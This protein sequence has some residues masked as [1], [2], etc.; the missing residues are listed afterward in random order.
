[1]TTGT[2]PGHLVLILPPWMIAQVLEDASAPV[3]AAIRAQLPPGP[4]PAPA[5]WPADELGRLIATVQGALASASPPTA[6]V[7]R[8]ILTGLV[9]GHMVASG[10]RGPDSGLYPAACVHA[11]QWGIDLPSLAAMTGVP[12]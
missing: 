12:R 10:W 4:A 5:G 3:A 9:I 7:M 1:M 8:G 2:A 11:R 6:G